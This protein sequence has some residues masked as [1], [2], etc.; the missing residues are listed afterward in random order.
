M[1]HGGRVI[2]Q[3]RSCG[4]IAVVE[5]LDVTLDAPAS[6]RVGPGEGQ[7]WMRDHCQ[8]RIT[9]WTARTPENAVRL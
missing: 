2:S 4:N 6:A 7:M 9:S 5:G 3:H 8:G 1:G